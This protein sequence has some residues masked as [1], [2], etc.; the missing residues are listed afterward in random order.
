MYN[1]LSFVFCAFLA[2]SCADQHPAPVEYNHN[3]L[4][5]NEREEEVLP[6][7]AY[8]N[9]EHT[10]ENISE[11]S[12]SINKEELQKT[13]GE[14]KEPNEKEDN[15]SLKKVNTKTIYYEVQKDDTIE[16]IAKRY[17]QSP[18]KIA[19]L[20]D[21]AEPYS[22]EESQIIMI[23]VS[24]DLLNRIN[25]NYT[26][27]QQLEDS[28]LISNKKFIKPLENGQI[29]KEFGESSKDGKSYGINIAAKRGSEIRSISSGKVVY[30]DFDKKFG[31]LIIVKL[32][33][34]DLHVAYSHMEDLLLEKNTIVKQGDIVGHV[35]STGD[36]SSP[37][38]HLAIRKGKESVDPLH[39][40]EK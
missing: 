35:G 19:K 21:L 32:D 40:I 17:E 12:F 2:S 15:I 34:G 25:K 39:Y 16:K 5:S 6:E 36:V 26:N 29:I 13:T 38:L 23:E 30:A 31:N 18:E 8:S 7:K 27:D 37:Q 1:F 33:E 9:A 28:K 4:I 22:L 24:Q 10:K 3:K 20:N 14:L 11:R